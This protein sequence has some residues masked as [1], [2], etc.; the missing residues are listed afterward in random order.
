MCGKQSLSVWDDEIQDFGECFTSL[1]LVSPAHALLA[2]ASAYYL[3]KNPPTYYI[4]T[5]YQKV[6]LY[7][8]TIVIFF[9]AACPAVAALLLLS[10]DT[11]IMEDQGMSGMFET[12]IQ[13]FSWC[14]HFAYTVMLFEKMCHSPRGHKPILF[15][16]VYVT[17]VDILQARSIL[18][19]DAINDTDYHD[20]ETRLLFGFAV[21]RLACLTLYLLT[22]LPSGDP[23]DDN[24]SRYEELPVNNDERSSLLGRYSTLEHSARGGDSYSINYRLSYNNRQSNRGSNQWVGHRNS[25]QQYGGFSNVEP[26]DPTYLGIAK[27][28][29]PL[30]SKLLFYWVHPLIKKGRLGKLKTT[31]DLFDVPVAISAPIVS[32]KFQ[33]TKAKVLLETLETDA[34]T[35]SASSLP[36]SINQRRSDYQ[37]LEGSE[38][39]VRTEKRIPLLK[40]F[41]RMYWRPFLVV[42]LL[43]F[44]ADC[45]GF[46]SPMLLNLMVKFMEDKTEDVRLGY[47]YALG[48]LATTISVALCITHFNLLMCELNLKVRASMIT[49]LY[50]HTLSLPSYRLKGPDFSVGQV[51][52]Y[53]S[54][55]TDRIVNFSPSLHALWSLP[56][57]FV[58][59]FYLLY[60]QLGISVFAGIVFTVAMIP[61]NKCI[62]DMI[63]KYSTKMMDA[64]DER[65]KCMSEVLQGIRV[66]KYFAWEDYFTNKVNK[67]RKSELKQLAGRKYMDAICV[68]LWAVTPVLISVTTFTTYVLMGGQ[69]TAA[70]VFTSIALFQMLTGPLNAFPWVLNGCVEAF[71]SIKRISRFLALESFNEDAYYSLMDNVVDEEQRER[72]EICSGRGKF[73][74]KTIKTELS[75]A[76]SDDDEDRITDHI[77]RLNFTIMKGEF[78][79][80]V[81]RVGS[82]KTSVLK[83]ILGEMRL[84]GGQL[85]F[86]IPHNGIGYVQQDPWLQQG[87]VKENI[88]YGKLH[89]PDWYNKVVAACALKEDFAKLSKGDLTDVGERGAA[90]SGGQKARVALAR[91]VYQD[92]EI[93]LIDDIFSAIDLHVGVQ[94]YH[95]TILGL[96]KHKTRVL[97]THHPRFLSAASKVIAMENGKTKHVGRPREVLSHLDIDEAQPRP[98]SDSKMTTSFHSHKSGSP[99]PINSPLSASLVKDDRKSEDLRK[100]FTKNRTLSDLSTGDTNHL[101]QR[102]FSNLSINN[103]G[104]NDTNEETTTTCDTT[105]IACQDIP[106]CQ[107]EEGQETGVVKLR[108]YKFYA[109]AVGR[110][111]CPLVFL[112]LLL[113]EGTKNS[114]D[115]W[116][117]QWV[118]NETNSRNRSY[119]YGND[120]GNHSNLEVDFYLSVYAGIAGANSIFA[121]VR[122][123]LFAYGGICAAKVVHE[124]LLRSIVKGK[125]VF[126]DRTPTGRILNR[127]SSDLKTVDDDLPFILNIFLAQLFGVIC[128]IIV[129]AYAV[130]WICLVL[131][132]VVFI[133]YDYQVNVLEMSILK[134]I[135]FN[136]SNHIREFAIL[137]LKLNILFI[138]GKISSCLS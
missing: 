102:T 37:V 31:E 93:Y 21:A 137:I 104:T 83:A 78:V 9:L 123:F 47:L 39:N 74:Y 97:V 109:K 46:A 73:S 58:V 42:G 120:S 6:A 66:M 55:D 103:E 10:L 81:G 22:L 86:K 43:R 95:K 94:I 100:A 118:S 130:P 92:K 136:N 108:M 44:L 52:N 54:I 69:L 128:P 8:R 113:M 110:L 80:I 14:F 11:T 29:A 49:A 28:Q 89:Q 57:Q 18:I 122:S 27:E 12:S 112:S 76:S 132:P 129:C 111:L 77:S 17:A 53:M 82:G 67:I 107:E 91:A 138:L 119:S 85:A 30:L 7:I 131:L 99:T 45:F 125:F 127:V 70:K 34:R 62:A 96:L 5:K 61:I 98:V 19:Q 124:K 59:S 63:G 23:F 2:I 133:L 90:L 36:F 24:G 60:N 48:L 26:S 38:E 25:S 71:V 105:T 88:L 116:L 33:H 40:I 68:F 79:G 101:R 20:V 3:G 117:A 16:W 56:F 72:A 35:S 75:R 1:F 65:V 51:I 114:T 15:I 126:F 106:L 115:I 50:R 64:K 13:T 87:T 84:E 4:R 134:K 121:I 32:D 135:R 41:S